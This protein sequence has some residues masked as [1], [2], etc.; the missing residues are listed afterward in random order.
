MLNLKHC[1]DVGLQRKTNPL[2]PFENTFR[3][4]LHKTKNPLHRGLISASQTAFIHLSN[5]GAFC[6]GR[7]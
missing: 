1:Q 4:F 5:S 7:L 6:S 3:F 2:F